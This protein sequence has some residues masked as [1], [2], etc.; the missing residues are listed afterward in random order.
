MHIYLCLSAGK[1]I[2]A[3]FAVNTELDENSIFAKQVIMI[4]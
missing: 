1:L 4:V 2:N 3:I